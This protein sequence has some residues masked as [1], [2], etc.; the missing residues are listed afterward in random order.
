[1]HMPGAQVTISVHPAAKMCKPGAPL[2]S[3]T[4][5]P[6][7]RGGYRILRRWGGGGGGGPG[8]C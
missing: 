3:N 8:N 5:R 7:Y 1:M 4:D 2:I 6:N